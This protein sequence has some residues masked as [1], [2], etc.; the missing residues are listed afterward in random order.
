MK[1]DKLITKA[2]QAGFTVSREGLYQINIYKSR[3]KTITLGVAIYL[4]GSK[5]FIAHRIDVALDHALAIRT[6]KQCAQILG[7]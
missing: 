1:L 3:G 2:E 5:F 4:D 7:L 6:V